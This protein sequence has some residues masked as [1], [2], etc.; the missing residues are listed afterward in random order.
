MLRIE[1]RYMI[2]RAAMRYS[3]TE[4]RAKMPR[5]R[6]RAIDL[7]RV[8]REQSWERIGRRPRSREKKL[9]RE[10]WEVWGYEGD[11]L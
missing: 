10:S 5:S 7:K 8:R 1:G 4:A 3:K 9:D 11:T 2:L 6:N